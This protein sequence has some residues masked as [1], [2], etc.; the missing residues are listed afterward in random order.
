MLEYSLRPGTLGVSARSSALLVPILMA[1]GITGCGPLLVFPAGELDGDVAPAPQDWDFTA[2]IRTVQLETPAVQ[3]LFRQHLGDQCGRRSLTP[4]RIA[5]DGWNISRRIPMSGFGSSPGS[6]C[7]GH[8]A[9]ILP[10]E[11]AR[12]VNAYER[13]YGSP[14]RN[15]DVTEAYLFRLTPR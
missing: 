12:F 7:C 15:R 2:E 5:R 11:F 10:A 3:A 8:N 13:R 6:T 4:A 9:S 14:P 1:L